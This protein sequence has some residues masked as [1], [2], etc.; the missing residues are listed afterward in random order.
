MVWETRLALAEKRRSAFEEFAGG[1][2]ARSETAKAPK[3]KEKA[4]PGKVSL[5]VGENR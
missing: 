5:H 2:R 4:T 1:G 3:K